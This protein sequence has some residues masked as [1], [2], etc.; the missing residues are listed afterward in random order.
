MQYRIVFVSL[1]DTFHSLGDV[2]HVCNDIRCMRF[3]CT[4]YCK[5]VRLFANKRIP[6]IQHIFTKSLYAHLYT[7]PRA[8][9]Y[10]SHTSLS[11]EDWT[12]CTRSINK[13][14]IYNTKC[15]FQTISAIIHTWYLPLPL[16]HSM[17]PAG[18]LLSADIIHCFSENSWRMLWSFCDLNQRLW[19]FYVNKPFKVMSGK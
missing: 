12:T 2:Q 17:T 3:Q 4:R 6:I 1:Y 15:A 10:P 8:G 7:S 14:W 13:L 19:V 5:K 16:G 11:A 18:R 9:A